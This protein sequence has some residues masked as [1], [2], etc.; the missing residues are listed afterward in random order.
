MLSH[1][2]VHEEKKETSVEELGQ[3]DTIDNGRKLLRRSFLSDPLDQVP[4][5]M[6]QHKVDTNNHETYGLAED[7]RNEHVV[8]KDFADRFCIQLS[9]S[10]TVL[11]FISV[12]KYLVDIFLVFLQVI[13]EALHDAREMCCASLFEI[14]LIYI[15]LFNSFF[16]PNCR[17]IEEIV[18]FIIFTLHF[19]VLL[20]SFLTQ[21]GEG[22]NHPSSYAKDAYYNQVY[23]QSFHISQSFC[24][25]PILP[26]DI[27]WL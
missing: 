1:V 19:R 5:S 12:F 8:I 2:G 7:E 27:G 16:L 22:V 10:C 21:N 18:L 4:D 11:V 14:Q 20:S 24:I 17:F 15:E 13:A 23:N 26:D 9:R 3:E 25:V 6:L